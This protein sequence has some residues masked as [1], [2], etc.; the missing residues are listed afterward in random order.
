VTLI[1][2][3]IGEPTRPARQRCRGRWPRLN[4]AHTGD[5]VKLIATDAQSSLVAGALADQ[6]EVGLADDVRR[7]VTVGYAKVA[8][9]AGALL[10]RGGELQTARE[11]LADPPPPDLLRDHTANECV[12]AD[13]APMVSANYLVSTSCTTHEQDRSALSGL[14]WVGA[15]GE[16][17]RHVA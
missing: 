12:I 17:R 15:T 13:S 10:S 14:D 9:G 2:A 3:S 1:V 16:R 5:E 8:S 7:E 11:Y 6:H 4:S